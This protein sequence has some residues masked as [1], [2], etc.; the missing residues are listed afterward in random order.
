MREGSVRIDDT[1]EPPVARAGE[2][3][4]I[5]SEG[6]S[7]LRTTPTWGPD[8]LW[9]L[10]AAPPFETAPPTLSAYIDWLRRETG[11]EID[12]HQ[13]AEDQKADLLQGSIAGLRP[14]QSIDV[15]LTAFDLSY[16]LEDGKLFVETTLKNN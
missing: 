16:R 8:W 7:S 14:D 12:L 6:T 4:E 2:E 15:V 9:I 3:L 13:L 1:G 11:W 5:D 10:E